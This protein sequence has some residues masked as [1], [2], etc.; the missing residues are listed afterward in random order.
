MTHQGMAIEKV[1]DPKCP[2][3]K[4]TGGIWDPPIEHQEAEQ[5][6]GTRKFLTKKICDCSIVRESENRS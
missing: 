4:G 3:C 1:P 2:K 6:A 5:R